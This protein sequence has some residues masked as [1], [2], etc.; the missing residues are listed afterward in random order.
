[1][2]PHHFATTN[3]RILC[4]VTLVIESSPVSIVRIAMYLTLLSV[5]SEVNQCLI[6]REE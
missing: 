1:M 6:D 4:I 2:D 5:P 3:E